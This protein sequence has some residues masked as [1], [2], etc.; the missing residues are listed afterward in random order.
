M[1]E[2]EGV[3]TVFISSYLLLQVEAMLL[4]SML[5]H[6]LQDPVGLKPADVPRKCQSKLLEA[7]GE[8]GDEDDNDYG[9]DGAL[10]EDN[11]DNSS[12]EGGKD[13]NNSNYSEKGH[14]EG[15]GGA[16]ED[17]E[18]QNSGILFYEKLKNSKVLAANFHFSRKLEEEEEEEEKQKRVLC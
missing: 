12:D 7:E 8:D 11:E 10:E 3:F 18:E 9:D 1:L 6:Q 14:G 16:E 4:V 5:I 2:V 13:Q 17:F 15:T